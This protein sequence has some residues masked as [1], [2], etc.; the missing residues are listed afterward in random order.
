[1]S[2]HLIR[3]KIR[4]RISPFINTQTLVLDLWIRVIVIY[5][6]SDDS[7]VWLQPV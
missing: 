7:F 5:N 3:R 4:V 1:M 2:I 6:R